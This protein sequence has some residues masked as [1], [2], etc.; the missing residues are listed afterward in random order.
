[1]KKILALLPILL[2]AGM[3]TFSAD[4]QKE[5][6]KQDAQKTTVQRMMVDPGGGG[7]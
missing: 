1:M 7:L 4:K 5:E 6:P 2:M 3:F